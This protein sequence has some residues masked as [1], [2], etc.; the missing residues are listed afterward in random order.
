M[1]V[2]A[3][4]I[5]PEMFRSLTESGVTGRAL[6]KGLWR[7]EAINPRKHSGNKH[8]YVDKRPY[9]GGPGMTMR[10]EPLWL[11]VREALEGAGDD[12]LVVAPSPQG[13]PVDQ[14][15]VESLAPRSTLVFVCGR[16]EGIDERFYKSVR[17]LEVSVGDL[18]VSGGELP[19]MMIID[20]V[21]RLLPGVLGDETSAQQDSFRDGLLE[22]PQYTHPPVWEGMEVPAVLT[23]GHHERIARWRLKQGILR[24]WQRRRDLFN[25]HVFN[26]EETGLL[27]ELLKE[28]SI[29]EEALA[30]IRSIPPATS[31]KKR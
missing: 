12:T 10:A 13:R 11:S 2:K 4:T 31:G 27:M 3:I 22:G 8:G 19:A 30:S 7:F 14:P 26:P 21:L 16:Y 23:S 17:P 18:V 24:T 28:G 25:R 15:L 1:D 6:E 9:G 29:P 5:F 20:A